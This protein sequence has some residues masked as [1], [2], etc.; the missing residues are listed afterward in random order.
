MRSK[1]QQSVI[2]GEDESATPKPENAAN[3]EPSF[4][5][6][7]ALPNGETSNPGER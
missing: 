1:Q 4:E 3:A 6:A 7:T 5:G 2:K